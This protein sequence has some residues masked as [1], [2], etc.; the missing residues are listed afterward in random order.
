MATF[1]KNKRAT[2][3]IKTKIE[4]VLLKL[5]LEEKI[6]LTYG[7]SFWQTRPVPKLGV[8]AVTMSDGPHGLRK[9]NIGEQG[10]DMLGVNPSEPAT[11][12]PTGVS[13]GSSW[14]THLA[15][16]LGE[17][18]AKE[19]LANGVDVFLGPG[20]NIKRNPLCGRNFEYYSEDPYLSGK[21]AASYIAKAEATG[22]G[23]SL[24]HFAA[25]GQEYSRF[26]SD[27]VLDE[28]ALREIYLRGFEIAVREGK[29]STVMCAYNKINGTYCSDNR[30]LLTD[31]LREEWGFD[32]MVVT[33]W[34]ALNN[35][36]EAFKAGCDLSMPG[37]S[38]YMAKAALNAVAEG[39]LKEA[40]IDQSVRRIL[41]LALQE[42]SASNSL[43]V[44]VDQ[45]HNLAREFAEQSAVLLQNRDCI[46]PLKDGQSCVLIGAMA[47][48]PRYQGAGSSLINPTR[49]VSLT[50]AMSQTPY[51]SGYLED[52]STNDALLSEAASLAKTAEVAVV[53]IGLPAAME[54]E[55]YDRADIRLPDGH[56][57]L[58][59][60]VAKANKNT[61]ILLFSGSAVEA[62]W[63]DRVKAILYMGLPGQAG[64][65]AAR[66]LLFGHANPSGRLAETWPLHYEDCPSSAVYGQR[67]ALYLESIYVGYRYYCSAQVPVRWGFGY[68]L[69]YTSFTYSDMAH[70]NGQVSVLVKNTGELPGAEVVQLYIIPSEGPVHRPKY[71]LKG[72]EKVWLEPGASKHVVFNLTRQDFAVW[73]KGWLVLG[74][75][76]TL[77]LCGGLQ[78]DNSLSVKV[79]VVGDNMLSD[80]LPSPPSSWYYH[81]KGKPDLASLESLMGSP[82]MVSRSQKGDYSF[83]DSLEDMRKDSFVMSMMY[84]GVKKHLL[85]AFG[86]KDAEQ[87]PAFKMIL[88]ATVESPIRSLMISGGLDEELMGGLLDMANRHP[89]RGLRKIIR[90][91]RKK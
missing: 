48:T 20:I 13:I 82:Y 14:D 56:N 44:D 39:T 22:A 18:I 34:G 63:A 89:L 91:K 86:G 84:K 72:F 67:D 81:L 2:H 35:R 65:E 87:S 5:S 4:E 26:V 46:L 70:R 8:P 24:K 61:V 83:N 38:T 57:R 66:N 9:Q 31:I 79:D 41:T 77:V 36:I 74:G 49:L 21:L 52:G 29:P 64:G 37:A 90:S 6:A 10:E 7:A 30:W 75:E 69:S 88:A 58:V 12:F 1:S 78:S 28:R 42:K 51:C 54:S 25:N 80:I 17:A 23:T 71:E 40:D 47:K 45:Q 43:C 55:G 32:G 27:S 62:P 11:C 33:D 59:E 3:D 73:Q 15:G 68:G 76:Y 60:E 50:E 85:K 16:K 19:A 53:C